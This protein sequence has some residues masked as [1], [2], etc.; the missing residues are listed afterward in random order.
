MPPRAL[1]DYYQMLVRRGL[2]GEGYAPDNENRITVIES[3]N[4]ETKEWLAMIGNVPKPIVIEDGD[5]KSAEASTSK[6]DGAGSAV[7]KKLKALQVNKPPTAGGSGNRWVCDLCGAKNFGSLDTYTR[8]VRGCG[9]TAAIIC[10]Y[11]TKGKFHSL[12]V[13][14]IGQLYVMN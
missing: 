10:P 13:S 14:F 5:D 12:S 1:L 8:H 3:N 11:C 7:K 9:K 4:P 2:S 6:A